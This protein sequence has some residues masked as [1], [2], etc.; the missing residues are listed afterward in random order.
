MKIIGVMLA[1]MDASGATLKDVAQAAG[2]S[3]MT[4]SRTLRN[5]P[6]VSE[7]TRTR[8]MEAAQRLGYRPDPHL[9]RMMQMVRARK[10]VRTR[11]VMA[12]LREHIPKD[13]LL[14]SVYQYVPLEDIRSRAQGYGYEVEEFWLGKAGMTPERVQSIL[15]ARGI[16]GVLVSP[17]SAELPCSRIDYAPFASV[18]FGN[19]MSTP[20][21]HMCAGNMNLGIQRT[22]ALLERRGYGR[23]GLAVTEWIDHR[24][25]NGYT[26]GL[27][28]FQ[29]SVPHARR[30]PALLLPHNNVA[31]GFEQFSVWLKRHRPDVLISF[32]RH[33]PG[34]L[35]RLGLRVPEDMGFVV[36][37]W[38]AKMP[39][40]AG[41]YQRRDQLAA[42]AVDLVVTQLSQNERGVPQVPRLL[43]IPPQWVEGS[44]VRSA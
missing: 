13:E 20:A 7:R 43:M 34:W 31:L 32:D 19:A 18:T 38:T 16:E 17:Q 39:G 44:S 37:D 10:H 22:A 9:H 25:Q 6:R 5:A 40:Y 3:I 42:A 26:A 41:I 27:Q 30:V 12:V 1:R 23:I 4:V 15:R 33:V 11:A 36:H 29:R 35:K 28:H 14:S 21:L 2:V 24:S 8:V